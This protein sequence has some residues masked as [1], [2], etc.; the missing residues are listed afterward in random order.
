MGGGSCRSFATPTA[1]GTQTRMTVEWISVA[2]PGLIWFVV[3]HCCSNAFASHWKTM[4]PSM[5]ITPT[6]P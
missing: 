6:A 3:R 1:C 4:F 2:S 5:R